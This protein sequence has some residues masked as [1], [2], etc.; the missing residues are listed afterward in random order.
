MTGISKSAISNYE[1]RLRTP[2]LK[3]AKKLSDVLMVP[4]SDILEM[5]EYD[6]NK[7]K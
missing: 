6:R 1:S 4:M 3:N 5:S 7:Q 2:D